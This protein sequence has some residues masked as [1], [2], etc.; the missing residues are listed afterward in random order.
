MIEFENLKQSNL[1]FFEEYKASFLNTLESGWYILGNTVEIFEQ[2]FAAYIGSQFAAGV[3]SGLDALTIALKALDLPEGSEV[4]VPS[5]TFVAT[6]ISIANNRL[7]PVLAEPNVHTYNIDPHNIKSV[8]TDKTKAII[9][10]HL[11]GKPCNMDPIMQIAKENDLKV[12]EDCAQAHGASYKGQNIGTFG[13]MAA[14][15]FYPTK[16][17]GA[18]GDGGAITTNNDMLASKIKSLRNY[19]STRKYYNDEL[20]F[21]SRLDEM[22][23]GFLNVKLKYL[24]DINNHKR[25]LAALYFDGLSD[26]CI[27]PVRTDHEHDVFHHFIIRHEERDRLKSFLLSKGIKTEIHYPVPPHHQKA[28]TNF[29]SPDATYPISE[30]LHNTVLSLPI[31]FCHTESD[32]NTVIDCVNQFR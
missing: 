17:L 15:S 23:A 27:K 13:D 1:P 31:A 25:S 19:G 4:I 32:V 11:Y 2:H 14:F 28:M 21:N 30:S 18:L 26:Q 8:L 12:I 3:G 16:N 9:P 6:L 7:I 29:F 10:V 5:N 24:D 22:Q 20:G